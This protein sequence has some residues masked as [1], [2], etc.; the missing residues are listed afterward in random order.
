MNKQE[1]NQETKSLMLSW[2]KAAYTE[3]DKLMGKFY[4]DNV[5][6]ALSH[7]DKFESAHD[8]LFDGLHDLG[9]YVD[10][11]SYQEFF[12]D[13]IEDGILYQLETAI[14]EA[15]E[16]L[17]Q[18]IDNGYANDG[19]EEEA[20]DAIENNVMPLLTDVIGELSFTIENVKELSTK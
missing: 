13:E 1:L 19:M 9:V 10:A 7:M 12:S 4:L 14:N 2:L 20:Q 18:L 11:S 8:R 17:E 3:L 5:S 16:E 15:K 6:L